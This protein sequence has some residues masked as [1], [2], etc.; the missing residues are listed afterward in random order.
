MAIVSPATFGVDNAYEA[1]ASEWEQGLRS[2]SMMFEPFTRIHTDNAASIRRFSDLP[3]GRMPNWNGSESITTQQVG[4][5][6]ANTY[7]P[8][9]KA[10]KAEI[11]NFDLI[12]NPQ[13]VQKKIAQMAD[14]V[15]STMNA[16]VFSALAGAFTA[17]YNTGATSGGDE[18]TIISTAHKHAGVG[19]G[20]GVMDTDQ[21]NKL[22]QA[23]SYDS[24]SNALQL[25][26]DFKDPSGEPLGLGRE[27]LVL[28]VPSALYADAVNLV[29]SDSLLLSESADNQGSAYANVTKIG[30]RNPYGGGYIQVVSSPYL[31]DANDW[32]LCE[33]AASDRT[34][35]NMW[36][37]GLPTI[38]VTVD[39]A[40]LKTVITA[41]AHVKAWV[42]GPSA[43]L[44]GSLVS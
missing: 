36:T 43:G 24:L 13:I 33:T 32:F 22:T 25:I 26:Q 38:N 20:D 40:N 9:G 7:T 17:T 4:A 2:R 39:E 29:G 23:L 19:A 35:V 16:E 21:S 41:A 5:V 6:N 27:G 15:V 11:L 34:P 12:H 1:L 10:F 30:S 8:Q 28:I 44:V 3:I 42:D 14:S 31:S 18:T 37:V